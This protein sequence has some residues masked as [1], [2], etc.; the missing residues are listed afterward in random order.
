MTVS[1]KVLGQVNPAINTNVDVYTVPA[2]KSAIVSTLNVC[3]MGSVDGTI[4]I[5][6]R[7][8]GE[9]LAAKHYIAYDTTVTKND[10]IGLTIG[11]TLA[12]GDVI[13][14]RSN[15]ATMTFNVFGS[16]IV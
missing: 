12:T 5:A 8:G 16:E 3:N 11:I 6:V 10:A 4:Q 7:P 1:Y 2:T 15:V 13:T 9:A 14:V